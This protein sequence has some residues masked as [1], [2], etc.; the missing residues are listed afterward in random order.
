MAIVFLLSGCA[1][2]PPRAPEPIPE[3][4]AQ[5]WQRHS[6]NVQMQTDWTL[7]ARVVAHTE[8]DSWNGKLSWHQ[9]GERYQLHFD[10]PFGQGAM[11][12]NGGPF[13]VEMRTSDGQVL[14]AAD[15][16][17]LLYQQLGWQ[18]PLHSLRYWVRGVPEP[19]HSLNS[20]RETDA[21]LL[22]FDELGRLSRLNQAQWQIE[23]PAYRQVNGVMLPKK[24]F[25]EN[26]ELSVR[27][28]ID[29]WGLGD[30][31]TR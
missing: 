19:E 22:A 2:V 31:G 13:Q 21:P 3:A 28:V 26:A 1:S 10:A 4:L 16:E 7:G 5:L 25:L 12:L 17:T 15:A 8:D 24:V 18:L 23:Y 30:P 9:A 29:Q 14:V 6:Q 27:L 20:D 11:Q